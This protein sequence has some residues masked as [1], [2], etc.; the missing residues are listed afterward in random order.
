LQ[1]TSTA[2]IDTLAETHFQR[3]D[4]PQAIV[5]MQKCA[6]LEPG[7]P[8]HKEQLEKYRRALGAATRPSAR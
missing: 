4:L 5:A 1:P 2:N 6:E 7:E 8:R 3:G